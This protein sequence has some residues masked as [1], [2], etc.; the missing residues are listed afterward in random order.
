MRSGS[1]RVSRFASRPW[2]ERSSSSQRLTFFRIAIACL[3]MNR[4][5]LL[6]A[7]NWVVDRIKIVNRWPEQDT[8]ALVQSEARGTGGGPCNLL[9]GL[10]RLRAPFP[11]E[12]LGLL[13][14]DEDGRRMI[15]ECRQHGI[16]TRFLRTTPARSTSY[17]EV[18]T[19]ADT[20]RRTFFHHHGANALL[21]AEHFDPSATSARILYLGY[22]SLLQS[23]D[24]PDAEFGTV[25]ARMLARYREAGF[26]TAVDAVSEI[27][28]RF[29][30]CVLPALKQTDYCIL[31]ELEAGCVAGV[32]A[33][34]GE[35]LNVEAVRRAG[36]KL[37]EHGVR[38]WAVIHFPEGAYAVSRSGEE[39]LEGSFLLPPGYIQSTVGAG[40]AFCGGVLFGLHEGWT[41]SECLKLAFCHA[42]ACLTHSTT[43]GGLRPLKETLQLAERFSRRT[44]GAA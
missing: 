4:R 32:A 10:A 5:G 39:C 28:D 41:M 17:T 30:S 22:L 26:K 3:S 35:R 9:N 16:Q 29:R 38:E 24:L 37:L 40:D 44:L 23:L 6:A 14:E 19:V 36:Q 12:A 1:S 2:R 11:L 33:R 13:G 20:G 42:A 43:T 31:N 27:S 8:L 34:E 18:I 15:E 7:G 25:A 21:G